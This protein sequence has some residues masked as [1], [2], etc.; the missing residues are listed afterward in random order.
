MHSL[1]IAKLWWVVEKLMIVCVRKTLIPLAMFLLLPVSSSL[2]C[3]LSN[4]DR[5]ILYYYNAWRDRCCLSL[6][7]PLLRWKMMSD[8]KKKLYFCHHSM[9]GLLSTSNFYLLWTRIFF[10]FFWHIWWYTF[11]PQAYFTFKN[12]N[13]ACSVN[14]L[15]W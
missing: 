6:I 5:P 11:F 8:T 15:A 12:L 10:T 13:N 9:I 1:K 2:E 3:C 7:K 4:I 14:L